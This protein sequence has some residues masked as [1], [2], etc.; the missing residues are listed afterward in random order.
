VAPARVAARRVADNAP[1]LKSPIVMFVLPM[2][3]ASSI[4]G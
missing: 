3:T 2:S 1:A 4:V